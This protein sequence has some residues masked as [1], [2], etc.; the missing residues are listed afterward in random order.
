MIKN[1][2]SFKINLAPLKYNIFIKWKQVFNE[3]FLQ[4]KSIIVN[5]HFKHF[6]RVMTTVEELRNGRE[7]FNSQRTQQKKSRGRWTLSDW[8]NH[9]LDSKLLVLLSL[10]IQPFVEPFLF[11]CFLLL[12]K[13]HSR[14]SNGQA[15]HI[16]F[17][18]IQVS[19]KCIST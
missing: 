12:K 9:L 14:R 8:V 3:C 5:Q 15:I 1:N 13:A 10:G 2:F 7:W 19:W 4:T 6:D 17:K 18:N 16:D 11:G